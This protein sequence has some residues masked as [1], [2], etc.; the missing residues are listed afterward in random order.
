[1]RNR[2]G[3]LFLKGAILR[4]GV[5]DSGIGGMTVLEHLKKKFARASFVYLGDTAHLP[6]GNKTSLQVERFAL[7]GL[8]RL[9]EKE[10]QALVVAC[11]TI[12]SCALP[13]IRQFMDPIPVIG[14]LEP[15]VKTVFHVLQ[16]LPEGR[17][18]RILVLATEATVRSHVY[19][20]A[21]E[22]MMPERY[23]VIEQD[24]PALASM[25]ERGW[26]GHPLLE[27]AI[28]RYVAPHV[29]LAPEEVGIALLAC[30]HYPWARQVFE[31]A[32]PGWTVVDA[33]QQTA[34]FLEESALM[35]NGL[36]TKK[37]DI[38]WMFTGAHVLTEFTRGLMGQLEGRS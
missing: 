21:L 15:A 17:C 20:H 3:F 34:S 8:Q 9:K 30:T 36:W 31:R 25:I 38:E 28:F 1:M 29:S 22:T 5:F 4:I 35:A 23:R 24:C 33:A 6:Y 10:I 14:M 16:T 12:S 7:D 19:R 13:A 18:I 27:E 2:L 37:P 11:H 32:L 26:E